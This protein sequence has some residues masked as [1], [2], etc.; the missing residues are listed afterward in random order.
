MLSQGGDYYGAT[1]NLASRIAGVAPPG[2]LAATEAVR[3]VAAGDFAFKPLPAE[4]LKGIEEEVALTEVTR[5]G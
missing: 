3:D 4:Q 1:V 2:S 5:K